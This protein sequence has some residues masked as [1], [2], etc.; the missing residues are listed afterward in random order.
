MKTMYLKFIK[1]EH[2]LFSQWT[3]N[4]DDKIINHVLP[5]VED[6]KC[7][8]NVIIVHPR[9]L[10]KRGISAIYNESLVL[11]TKFNVL[12]TCYWCNHVDYLYSTESNS[13]IQELRT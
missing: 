13:N 8:K 1:T 9:F 4:I 10:R 3:R 7:A 12:V 5:F 2:F 6:T 11:V